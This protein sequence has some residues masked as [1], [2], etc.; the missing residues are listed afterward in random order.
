M[1]KTVDNLVNM[2]MK[3]RVMVLKWKGL[4][5]EYALVIKHL[6]RLGEPR[7]LQRGEERKEWEKDLTLSSFGKSI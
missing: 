6:P 4:S 5:Q 7:V 3:P 2:Q 1:N